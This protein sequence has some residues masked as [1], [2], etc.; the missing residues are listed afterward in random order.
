M[1]SSTTRT[2][3]RN[4]KR[5]QATVYHFFV[6]RALSKALNGDS[7]TALLNAPL[8]AVSM[9]EDLAKEL[10]IPWTEWTRFETFGATQLRDEVQREFFGVPLSD[11]GPTRAYAWAALGIQWRVTCPNSYDTICLVEQF[12]AILQIALADLA[13]RDLCLLPTSV[14][15]QV[16]LKAI[17]RAGFEMLP[18]NNASGMKV[19]L[20]KMNAASLAELEDMQQDV[21]SIALAVLTQCSCLSDKDLIRRLDSA[22]R[23][24]LTSKVFIVR[25]YS[26]L[27]AQFVDPAE[28]DRRRAASLGPPDA[29]AY[30]VRSAPELA[31]LDTPGPGYT[32]EKARIALRNRYERGASP[33]ATTIARVRGNPR[34]QEWV[35]QHRATGAR[36]GGSFSSS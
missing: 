12:V 20:P 31:W 16:E 18:G 33:I 34:F 25:P 19:T 26:D 13:Q 9:P 17:H 14:S 2:T 11:T 6:A 8:A 3:G 10:L 1:S 24:G 4:T 35:A 30:I 7:A 28:Y 5:L 15:I 32:P 23:D 27:F 22:F 29:S 21:C 36:T